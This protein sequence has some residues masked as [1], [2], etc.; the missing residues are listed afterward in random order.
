MLV[1]LLGHPI[2]GRECAGLL[3]GERPSRVG[4]ARQRGGQRGDGAVLP[5]QPSIPPPLRARLPAVSLPTLSLLRALMQELIEDQEV[6]TEWSYRCG[7][8]PR[9]C[10]PAACQQGSAMRGPPCSAAVHAHRPPSADQPLIPCSPAQLA[11]LLL[12]FAAVTAAPH[13]LLPHDYRVTWE[14]VQG[15]AWRLLKIAEQARCLLGLS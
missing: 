5:I 9:V 15:M 2:N 1:A 13:N 6:T 14:W 7:L 12:V 4:A 8:S 10:P 3:D 11:R